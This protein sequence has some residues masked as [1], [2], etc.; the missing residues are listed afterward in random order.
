V[1]THLDARSVIDGGHGGKRR[2]CPPY[3]SANLAMTVDYKSTTT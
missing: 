3:Q 2:L 1:P